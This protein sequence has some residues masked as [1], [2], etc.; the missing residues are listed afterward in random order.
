MDKQSRLDRRSSCDTWRSQGHH[1]S[2]PA[3]TEALKLIPSEH[4]DVPK[5]SIMISHEPSR[6]HAGRQW[7][8]VQAFTDDRTP[9]IVNRP[10]LQDLLHAGQESLRCSANGEPGR[11]EDWDAASRWRPS[12]LLT[13]TWETAHGTR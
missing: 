9:S 4:G 11:A 5:R 10:G 3:A 7:L 2:E 6:E 1:F 12:A 13:G 8:V